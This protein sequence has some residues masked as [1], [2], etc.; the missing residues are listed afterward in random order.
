MGDLKKL[1]LDFEKSKLDELAQFFKNK[2][3]ISFDNSNQKLVSV[4][5][6][7]Y[8]RAELT[9]QCLKSLKDN[10]HIP[11]ELIVIDNNSTDDT[12][13]LFS[14]V[15]GV[16]YIKNKENKTSCWLV[17][18]QQTLLQVNICFSK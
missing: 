14:K 15:K 3:E 13:K 12:S 1:K 9:L 2:E 18:R 7:L 16:N 6:V 4:I 5:L 17:I 11:L 8:N 10:C